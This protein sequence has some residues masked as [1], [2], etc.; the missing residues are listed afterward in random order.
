MSIFVYF[1]GT[2]IV[3]IKIKKSK[4]PDFNKSLQKVIILFFTMK[5]YLIFIFIS[6]VTFSACKRSPK[7]IV[8]N[9]SKADVDFVSG[10][11]SLTDEVLEGILSPV[12]I[13]AIIKDKKIAYSEDF[14][15]P[16]E[17][18]ARII[19]EDRKALLL[20]MLSVDL[21]YLNL[22]HQ[23]KTHID[24]LKTIHRLSNELDADLNFD[25]QTLRNMIA[26]KIDDQNLNFILV[27][28]YHNINNHFLERDRRDLSIALVTGAWIESLY[29]AC[30]D[31]KQTENKMLRDRIAEQK[32]ILSSLNKTIK[33]RVDVEFFKLLYQDLFSLEQA[34]KP[35]DISIENGETQIT[36]DSDGSVVTQ[37]ETSVSKVS[38][39]QLN[40]IIRLTEQIRNGR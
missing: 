31:N 40:E 38:D 34:Y 3:W 12:E 28:N 8:S 14:I 17:V 33:N 18:T 27:E 36:K 21:A 2:K 5:K 13:A 11:D 15:L 9:K 6:T 19:S 7:T 24:N 4:Q 22:N 29:L 1:L 25:F 39:A 20:G 30:R 26:D 10:K 16:Q 32:D 35:V 23:I 37:G